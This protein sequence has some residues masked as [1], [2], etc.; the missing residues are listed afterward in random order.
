VP[1]DFQKYQDVSFHKIQLPQQFYNHL[2]GAFFVTIE[3]PDANSCFVGNRIDNKPVPR[4]L[5]FDKIDTV[6]YITVRYREALELYMVL[7][8]QPLMRNFQHMHNYGAFL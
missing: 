1:T 8:T 7:D 4:E 5:L 2:P 3:K 6:L